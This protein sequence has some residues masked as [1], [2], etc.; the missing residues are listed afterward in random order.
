VKRFSVIATAAVERGHLAPGLA[1]LGD[2]HLTPCR[3]GSQ[4]LFFTFIAL[5]EPHE[6]LS[7]IM[8]KHSL[9]QRASQRLKSGADFGSRF[10]KAR[11]LSSERVGGRR[12]GGV[13]WPEGQFVSGQRQRNDSGGT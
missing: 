6:I 2:I 8:D 3:E 11:R 5:S 12:S 7:R 13:Y 9:R 10:I 4:A 1:F